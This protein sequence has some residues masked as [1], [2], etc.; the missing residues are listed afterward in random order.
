[1]CAESIA[2]VN[3]QH[4][5]R[6]QAAAHRQKHGKTC[7]C[8][9]GLFRLWAGKHLA[10]LVNDRPFSCVEGAIYEHSNAMHF[11]VCSE[12]ALCN[13]RYREGLMG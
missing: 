11:L 4:L 2:C 7:T 3:K 5:C 12:S 1:M 6:K 13:Y 9:G 8:F 10:Q